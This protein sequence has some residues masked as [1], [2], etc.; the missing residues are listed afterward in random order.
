LYN[1]DN[2]IKK[3][4]VNMSYRYG[5]ATL[6]GYGMNIGAGIATYMGKDAILKISVKYHMGSFSTV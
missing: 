3:G 6:M 1:K 5:D 2:E 4:S